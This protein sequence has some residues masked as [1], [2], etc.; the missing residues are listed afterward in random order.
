M[1]V[2]IFGCTLKRITFVFKLFKNDG[3]DV[4]YRDVPGRTALML[5]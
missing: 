4:N 3:I 2:L 5:A 1:N